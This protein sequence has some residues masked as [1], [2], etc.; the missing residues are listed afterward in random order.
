MFIKKSKI[1]KNTSWV[2]SIATPC[3]TWNGFMCARPQL[4]VGLK[5]LLKKLKIVVYLGFNLS[6]YGNNLGYKKSP[7]TKM[8]KASKSI[9]LIG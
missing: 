3:P 6:L 1:I 4:N 7:T 5:M 9:N 8:F 2:I